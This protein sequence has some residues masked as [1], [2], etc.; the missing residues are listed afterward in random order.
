MQYK[1]LIDK[2][3]GDLVEMECGCVRQRSS[4][5]PSAAD[6]VSRARDE[7]RRG[8]RA[9][10]YCFWPSLGRPAG[11]LAFLLLGFSPVEFNQR[12][13][14]HIC[15]FHWKNLLLPH[16]TRKSVQIMAPHWEIRH[17]LPVRKED[18]SQRPPPHGQKLEFVFDWLDI[19]SSFY[20]WIMIIKNSPTVFYC[21]Q[22]RLL[23]GN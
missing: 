6:P 12:R 19:L 11:L 21:T 13:K 8:S 10:C 23:A 5:V 1:Y 16:L 18:F 4:C 2:K 20:Y 15:S 3:Q 22:L 7:N 9:S 14:G 17:Q